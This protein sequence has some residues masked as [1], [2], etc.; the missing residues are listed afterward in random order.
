MI[1]IPTARTVWIL[2][3]LAV[4]LAVVPGA[5]QQ[6][7]AVQPRRGGVLRVAHIGEPPSLDMQWTSAAITSH[8]MH[9]V[10]EGLFALD[11]KWQ[12]KPLLLESWNLSRDRLTYTFNLRRGVRF[13]NGV[14][15]KLEDQECMVQSYDS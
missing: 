4:S 13:H 7:T 9:N 2:V 11:G 10:Y 8:I 3:L 14:D 15:P 6:G 12:P 1:R 5:A